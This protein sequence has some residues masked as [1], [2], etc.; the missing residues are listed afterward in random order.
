MRELITL[1]RHTELFAQVL[2]GA[3]NLPNGTQHVVGP[4]ENIQIATGQINGLNPVAFFVD[5]KDSRL[6]RP[7]LSMS[8]LEAMKMVLK[9]NADGIV[10]QNNKNSHFGLN[11]QGVREALGK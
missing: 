3:P 7:F 5:P 9:M 8:G 2:G 11:A 10:I 4:N 6:R 1:L